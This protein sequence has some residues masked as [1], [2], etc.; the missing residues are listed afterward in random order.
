ML[1]FDIYSTPTYM[2]A[3]I[4]LGIHSSVYEHDS[5]HNKV[6]YTFLQDE[7]QWYGQ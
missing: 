6:W 1:Q 5:K 7:S 2:Q 3:L 4:H